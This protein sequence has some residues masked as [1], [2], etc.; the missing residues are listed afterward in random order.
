MPHFLVFL[1][2]LLLILLFKMGP[3]HN[4]EML[5][6]VPKYKKAVMCLREKIHISDKFCSGMSYNVA[7]SEFNSNESTIYIK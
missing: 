1:C 7:G 6:S 4:A 2:F 5:S 3:T